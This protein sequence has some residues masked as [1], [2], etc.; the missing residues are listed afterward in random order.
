MAVGSPRFFRNSPPV[1]CHP[2]PA[3]APAGTLLSF[4]AGGAD[5]RSQTIETL[6]PAGAPPGATLRMQPPSALNTDGSRQLPPQMDSVFNNVQ[7]AEKCDI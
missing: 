5:G 4:S 6:V 3:D 2:V 7:V 1:V